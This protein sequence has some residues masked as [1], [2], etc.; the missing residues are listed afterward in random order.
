MVAYEKGYRVDSFGD[1]YF[2]G[3]KRSLN[4]SG[5]YYNFSVKTR[6]NNKIYCTR[7]F[8]HRLQAYQKYK[9]DIFKEGVLVRHLDSNCLN[10]SSENISIGT[11][12]DNM[13]DKSPEVRMRAALIAT[14]FVKIYN[15]EEVIKMHKNGLSYNDIMKIT[16]IKGKGAVSFIINKSI[17]SKK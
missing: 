17:E 1:V 3:T 13:M 16:G 10:N 4:K 2:R 12:S 5:G 7:V 8:V 9:N 15:H 6:F 11:G 14:S